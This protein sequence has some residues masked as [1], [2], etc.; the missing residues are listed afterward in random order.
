MSNKSIKTQRTASVPPRNR[1]DRKRE[2]RERILKAAAGVFARRGI[3]ATTTAEVAREAGV[4]HGSVFAHFGSQEELVS[5]VI[6]DFGEGV[7]RRLHE[8]AA[9]GAGVREVLETHL[10]AIA[11]RED[12]YARLAVEAPLLPP[13]ARESL[14]AIQSAICFH[15]SPALEGDIRAGRVREQP[16]HLF[17]NTWAGLLHYYMA[18]GELFAPGASVIR[19]RGPELL[20]YFMSLISTGGHP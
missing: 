13:R 8:L 10:K 14:I 15:L 3:L 18:N 11:E 1:K 12:F 17:F 7:A 20:E 6:E 5:A 19:R 9:A 4:S 16:L 2:T